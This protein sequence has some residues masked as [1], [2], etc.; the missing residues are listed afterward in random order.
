MIKHLSGEFETVEYDTQKYAMLYDNVQTEEYPV[1]WHNAV[2]LIMPM[3]NEYTVTVN[4]TDYFIPENDVLIVPPCELHSMPAIPGRRIIFQCDNS[5]LGEITAL[6]PVMR[7]LNAPVLICADMDKELHVL[8]KKTM[9]DILSLYNSKSEL[10]DVKI[11]VKVIELFMA[12]RE[13][14]LEQQKI[15]M[16][17]DDEKIDEYSEKFGTVLKYIDNNYMYDITLEQLA[18]VAGYSKYHFSRIF[19]QYNAMSYLQY[20]NARRTKAAEL[21]LLDPSVPIT[22]VAMRSGFK[23]LTTFN[24]IFK[25]IK[26]CTPTDFKKLYALR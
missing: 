16:D 2:E 25:E 14:Q 12:L 3:K 9:L 5:I 4:G 1:H 20:I 17:C 26:H 13:Y 21:L 18:D 22:E 23:S 24:R 19:K 11:Y 10:A 7:S 8:A 15:V 6:E